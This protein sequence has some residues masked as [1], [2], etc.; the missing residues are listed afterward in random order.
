MTPKRKAKLIAEAR[1]L[2]ISEMVIEGVTYKLGHTPKPVEMTE[3]DLKNA[4]KF[5]SPLDDLSDDEVL[6][7]HSSYFDE[8][9]EQKQLRKEQI[10]NKEDING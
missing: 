1:E 4:V 2:G 10:K 3:A 8:L 9:Q 6:Y 7:Y 5:Q